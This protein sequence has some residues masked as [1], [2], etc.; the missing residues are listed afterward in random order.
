M[1]KFL[2]PALL[3]TA[4]ALTITARAQTQPQNCAACAAPNTMNPSTLIAQRR[5]VPIN[6][7]PIKTD[8]KPALILDNSSGVN[9]C[10]PLAMAGSFGQYFRYHQQPGKNINQ[11]Y[12]LQFLSTF[13]YGSTPETQ[14]QTLALDQQMYPFAF[15][16]AS[17]GSGLVQPGN[18]PN[19]VLL[20]AEVKDFGNTM[21][22]ASGW[23]TGATVG[24]GGQAVRAWWAGIPAPSTNPQNV[25]DGANTS[26]FHNAFADGSSVLSGT[27]FQP[28]RWYMMKLKLVFAQINPKIKDSWILTDVTCNNM[29]N[30]YVRFRFDAASLK[31]AAGTTAKPEVKFEDVK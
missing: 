5:A 26:P 29:K 17:P 25:W 9:T 14:P 22:I 2:M 27:H 30:Q 3:I 11:T 1:N 21:P 28:N 10:C 16:L 31:T 24:G 23:P 7:V 20:V 12:G 13:V 6:A 15:Y 19:S 4:A 18:V 8:I